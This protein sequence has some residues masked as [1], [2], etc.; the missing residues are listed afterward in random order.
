MQF[1][2]FNNEE[3]PIVVAP[4]RRELL[5]EFLRVLTPA[6]GLLLFLLGLTSK[7]PWLAQPWVKDFLV[8]LGILVV[9]WFAGPRVVSWLTRFAASPAKPGGLSSY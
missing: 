5:V 9:A 1:D 6:L 7:Y 3:T 4:P 8:V 2:D